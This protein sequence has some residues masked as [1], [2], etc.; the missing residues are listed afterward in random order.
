[1]NHEEIRNY[2]KNGLDIM[3][4]IAMNCP[5]KCID[6][7]GEN[8]TIDNST[9]RH[10]MHCINL[11]PKALK[12]GKQRGA[13]IL[14]G[15]KAPIV[16]GALLS[17]VII[18]FMELDEDHYEDL[19]ELVDAMVDVWCEE[20]KNRERIGE[21]NQRVGLGNFLEAVGLEPTPEM[22]SHPRDNPYIFYEHVGEEPAEE[23][24]ANLEKKVLEEV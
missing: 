20:G 17:S 22:L 3:R 23:G 5:G 6:W 12:P 10:C 9:C 15:A 18:P 7:D 21:F 24:A 11:M 1:M 4:E 19:T 8:M 2:A 14:V 16:E 13:S